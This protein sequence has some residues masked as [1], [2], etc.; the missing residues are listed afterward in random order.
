M[1]VTRWAIS[2]EKELAKQIKQAARE[3]ISAW[4][5]DAARQKLR[6]DRLLAVIT[7][8]E[9]ELGAF[10]QEELDEARREIENARMGR[11]TKTARTTTTTRR[12]SRR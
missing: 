12:K 9:A 8:Y 6:R 5:A 7:E 1:P 3:P 2:L 11:K 4:L 10:T